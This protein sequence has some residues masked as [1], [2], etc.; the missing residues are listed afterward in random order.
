[1]SGSRG[2][3]SVS[4]MKL[5]SALQL[6]DCLVPRRLSEP[7]SA[8]PVLPVLAGEGVHNGKSTLARRLAFA[9]GNL[10]PNL[11]PKRIAFGSPGL[12]QKTKFPQ[13]G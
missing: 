6:A 11:P 5:A 10:I 12:Q 13:D 3:Y 4:Q 9:S 1:M 7:S 2:S 8:E